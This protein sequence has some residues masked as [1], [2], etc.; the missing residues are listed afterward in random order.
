MLLRYEIVLKDGR[1]IKTS[2]INFHVPMSGDLQYRVVETYTTKHQRGANYISV[3]I[4]SI[5]CIFSLAK[6][7]TGRIKVP[8]ETLNL[9]KKYNLYKEET[10]EVEPDGE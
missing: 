6:D 3:P 5:K 4:K 9:L 7:E 10:G 8:K 2:E 1:R